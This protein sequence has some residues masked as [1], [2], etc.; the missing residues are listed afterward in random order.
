MKLW[1]LLS[2]LTGLGLVLTAC[3]L[4]TA[5]PK[6]DE[7][8]SAPACADTIRTPEPGGKDGLV[9][10]GCVTGADGKGLEGVTIYRGYAAY[11]G[12]AVAVSGP[13]GSYQSAFMPIPGDEMVRVWAELDGTVFTGGSARLWQEG[14][15]AWRHYGGYEAARLDFTGN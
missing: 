4:P 1:K 2:V 8:T 15:Y 9:V 11:P 13:D 10:Y 5:A 14:G 7:S 6:A 12:E 3:F